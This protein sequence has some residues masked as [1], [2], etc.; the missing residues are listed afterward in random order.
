MRNRRRLQNQMNRRKVRLSSLR[1]PHV[2]DSS[3]QTPRE[4]PITK[5]AGQKGG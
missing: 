4:L 3:D 1:T 5:T 2:P